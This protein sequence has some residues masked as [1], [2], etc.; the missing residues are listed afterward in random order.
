MTERTI[1]WPLH[2]DHRGVQCFNCEEQLDVR[3]KE[4]GE[5]GHGDGAYSQ[6]CPHCLMRTFYDLRQPLKNR[7]LVR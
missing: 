5:E 7:G 1:R 2:D 4:R 6:W 3:T